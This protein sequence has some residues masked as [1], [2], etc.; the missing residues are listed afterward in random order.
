MQHGSHRK[1]RVSNSSSAVACLV[2]AAV[3]CL[4]SRC[5]ATIVG[6]CKQQGDLISLL[7]FFQNKEKKGSLGIILHKR[8]LDGKPEW[9]R[10]LETYSPIWKDNT[11]LFFFPV[12]CPA[13]HDDLCAAGCEE[14][15]NFSDE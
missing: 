2:V 5:L 12:H 11:E 7:L 15:T 9:K 3:T 8:L 14:H 6:I 10:Q 4:P 1:H 13:F